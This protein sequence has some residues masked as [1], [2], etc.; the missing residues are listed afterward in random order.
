M[1]PNF[2]DISWSLQGGTE[3]HWTNSLRFKVFWL[4][5]KSRILLVNSVSSCTCT[6]TSVFSI[7]C[8]FY[9]GD[10]NMPPKKKQRGWSIGSHTRLFRGQDGRIRLLK[11]R[12][13]RELEL[14]KAIVNEDDYD[15]SCEEDKKEAARPSIAL[16]PDVDSSDPMDLAND[17]DDQEPC[18][19][20]NSSTKER[21]DNDEVFEATL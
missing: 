7:H 18:Q 6:F 21:G 15:D 8:D 11:R 16:P 2:Q 1:T 9:Q 3:L 5:A 12:R 14:A 13:K 10:R 17:S 19:V 4:P 20:S